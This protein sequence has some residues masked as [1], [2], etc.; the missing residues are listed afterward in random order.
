MDNNCIFGQCWWIPSTRTSLHRPCSKVTL[1]NK[2]SNDDFNF[3]YQ[4]NKKAC[5]API[6]K[7]ILIFPLSFVLNYLPYTFL[8]VMFLQ[9]N[10][11]NTFYEKSAW[12]H[13]N[14]HT[15]LHCKHQQSCNNKSP[16]MV[17]HNISMFI[18]LCIKF[19]IKFY[20]FCILFYVCTIFSPTTFLLAIITNVVQ[21]VFSTL[22]KPTC[23][24]FVWTSIMPF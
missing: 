21:F 8:L 14:S 11:I 22:L 15:M 3:L 18:F 5:V 13:W 9:M 4:W 16:I 7:F 12:R 2:K 1:F 6:I 17:N 20:T 19:L 24:W 23:F 10:S